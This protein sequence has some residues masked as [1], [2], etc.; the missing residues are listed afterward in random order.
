MNTVMQKTRALIG[1][2]ARGHDVY[3]T[4]DENG[5]I[6]GGTIGTVLA[7]PLPDRRSTR[8]MTLACEACVNLFNERLQ[9]GS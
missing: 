2:C 4:T 3:A 9:S 6:D 1:Q 7:R 5:D 8:P